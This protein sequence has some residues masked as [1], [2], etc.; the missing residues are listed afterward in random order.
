M[1]N[2]ELTD[3]KKVA[4]TCNTFFLTITEKVN[5]QQVEKG[6]AVSFLEDSF[7]VNFPS[8]TIIPIT[9]AEIKS[10]IHCLKPQNHQIMMK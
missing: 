5:K 1:N 6:D 9:E 3:P 8:M 4:N 10:I 7:P 2:D